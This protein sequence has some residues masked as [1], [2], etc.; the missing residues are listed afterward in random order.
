MKLR[1]G[2]GQNTENLNIQVIEK[3]WIEFLENG[4]QTGTKSTGEFFYKESCYLAPIRRE[5]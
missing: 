5:I 4:S 3:K 2:E 1:K